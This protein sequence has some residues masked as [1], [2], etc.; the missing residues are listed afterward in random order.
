MGKKKGSKKRAA[1]RKN[2]QGRVRPGDL[3]RQFQDGDDGL[4]DAAYGERVSGKGELTRKRTV[5]GVDDQ[6]SADTSRT[7][8]SLISGRVI[9]VHGLKSRVLASDGKTYD[10]AVR[11]VL[12]S[13]SIEQRNVV[14]F[15]SFT[16]VFLV[17]ATK[18]LGLRRWP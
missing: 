1:F 16:V 17:A 2:Y 9:S 5:V 7:D 3:T 8:D 15:V 11:Q 12:K 10:C 18:S 13:L 6:Q 14:Y 4:A